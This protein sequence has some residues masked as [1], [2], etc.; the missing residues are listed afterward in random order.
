MT[1]AWLLRLRYVAIEN[2]ITSIRVVASY[3][4][5]GQSM[6]EGITETGIISKSEKYLF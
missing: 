6:G 1:R 2:I 5:L 3:P 4:G